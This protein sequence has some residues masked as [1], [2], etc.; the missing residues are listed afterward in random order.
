MPG[1][2]RTAVTRG[3]HSH[4]HTRAPRPRWHHARV[5][6]H[7]CACPRPCPRAGSARRPARTC[8]P[9]TSKEG[10]APRGAARRFRGRGARLPPSV[11]VLSR[12]GALL[13]GRGRRALGG[14]A[15]ARRGPAARPAERL[16]RTRPPRLAAGRHRRRGASRGGDGHRLFRGYNPQD[17]RSPLQMRTVSPGSPFAFLVLARLHASLQICIYISLSVS[18]R[19]ERGVF[20]ERHTFVCLH[21]GIFSK[22]RATSVT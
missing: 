5:P 19:K 10:A 12:A 21:G 16:R 6:A 13:P 20:R 14:P 8:A 1:A 18:G 7:G 9:R 11:A 3:A 22:A 4:T 2:F 17:A 15:G